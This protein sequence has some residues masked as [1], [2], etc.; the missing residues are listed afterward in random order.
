LAVVV[1]VAKGYNLRYIWKTQGQASA[2]RTPGGYDINAAQAGE[3]PGRWGPRERKHSASH[4][5]W[6][7]NASP[8]TPSTSST[9]RGPGQARPTAWPLRD[10]RRS[11]GHGLVLQVDLGAAC[12]DPGNA[13]RA[14]LASDDRALA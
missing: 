14:W 9:I 1:T 2:G 6:S 11:P 10:V 4:P 7:L 8:M 5:A 13:R 3:P 12:L